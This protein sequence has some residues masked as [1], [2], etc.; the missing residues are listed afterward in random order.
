MDERRCRTAVTITRRAM[1]STS[2]FATI[3]IITR[4]RAVA[5]TGAMSPKPTVVNMV[6]VKYRASVRVSSVPNEPGRSCPST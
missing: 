3:W 2:R 6:T 5:E 1:L 4:I